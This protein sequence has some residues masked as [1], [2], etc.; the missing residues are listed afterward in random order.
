MKRSLGYGSGTWG[1]DARGES[2]RSEHH[3][4]CSWFRNPASQLRLVVFRDDL[5]GLY[6]PG[7]ADFFQQQYDK[8]FWIFGVMLDSDGVMGQL[9]ERFYTKL[10]PGLPLIVSWP[11]ASTYPTQPWEKNNRRREEIFTAVPEGHGVKQKGQL[12]DEA[13]S[14]VFLFATI[15][16]SSHRI[17]VW[18]IYLH[19]DDCLHGWY[20]HESLVGGFTYVFYF[21]P[22]RLGEEMNPIWLAHIFQ[23]WCWFN[24]QLGLVFFATV[25]WSWIYTPYSLGMSRA[26]VVPL[27]NRLFLFLGFL[28]LAFNSSFLEWQ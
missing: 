25:W 7:S 13:L 19:L 8:S 16:W 28:E 21:H 17:H 14:R 10:P 1:H 20:G 2:W 23:K 24:H 11:C 27:L 22:K 26:L 3:W 4:Y 12:Q 5:Q 9:C 18:Y 6:I 15:W